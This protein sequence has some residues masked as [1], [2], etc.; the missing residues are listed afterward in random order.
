M[1]DLEKTK[2]NW[3][4]REEVTA[5][6]LG[7]LKRPSTWQSTRLSQI[8]E[9]MAATENLSPR[10]QATGSLPQPQPQGNSHELGF[11]KKKKKKRTK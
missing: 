5:S 6:S 8:T 2:F 11:Y 7:G 4:A 3:G 10:T 1:S 9:R